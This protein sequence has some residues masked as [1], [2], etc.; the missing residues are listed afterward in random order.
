M[1]SFV[2]V[3]TTFALRK[4]ATAAAHAYGVRPPMI[5]AKV[6]RRAALDKLCEIIAAS[7]GVLLGRGDLGVEIPPE[8]VPV[9][10]RTWW[11]RAVVRAN[12]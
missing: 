10:Q 4:L 3:P 1:L 11:K 6:E 2:T 7:D 5:M 8:E 12:P 9:V